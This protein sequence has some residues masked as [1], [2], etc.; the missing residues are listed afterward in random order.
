MDKAD[1]IRLGSALGVPLELTLSCMQP[2]DG[3]HCGRCSKCRERRDAFREA[4]I[5]DP[6]AYA[7][8]PAR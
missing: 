8:A 6:T 5:E 4:G 7:Q 1:V 2:R 3:L